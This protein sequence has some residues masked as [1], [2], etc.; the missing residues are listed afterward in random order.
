MRAE[1]I[2]TDHPAWVLETQYIAYAVA[3]IICVLSPQRVILGG[4]VRKAGQL[5]EELF[6]R[7]IRDNVRSDL[8]GYIA[9]PTLDEGLD[10]Y[11]VPPGLGDDAG[12]CGALA[13]G[14]SLGG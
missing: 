7:W 1:D 6:F 2:P 4:G 14:Q 9:S 5:G 3:N 12:I 13:L 8:N 11:I 10:S